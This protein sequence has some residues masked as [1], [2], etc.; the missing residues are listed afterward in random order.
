VVETFSQKKLTY[1]SDKLPAITGLTQGFQRNFNT[2]FVA[3]LWYEDL[4]QGLL[5]ARYKLL[6]SNM[7]VNKDITKAFRICSN[8]IKVY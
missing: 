4:Y 8:K 2:I 1:A 5:L 3:G 7:F 6:G